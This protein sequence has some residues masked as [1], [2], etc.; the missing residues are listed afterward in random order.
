MRFAS[1]R[2]FHLAFACCTLLTLTACRAPQQRGEGL[3]L[4]R[5]AAPEHA[6]WLDSLDLQS[7][8]QDWGTPQVGRSVDGN[9]LSLRG[10]VYPR[11]VGTHAT[12]VIRVDLGGEAL[13][14]H[15]IAGVDDEVEQRGSVQFIVDIDGET[16][17][18]SAVLRGGGDT[19]RVDIDLTGARMMELL[20]EDGGDDINFDHADWAGALLVMKP[21]ARH[22]PRIIAPL[23]DVTM[24]IAKGMSD[25]PSINGPAITGATPGNPFLYR[26]P[27]TG[28]RPLTFSAS[29]LPAGLQLDSQ[30]GIIS[31]TLQAAGSTDVELTVQGPSGAATRV[32]KIVGGDDALA[33]TP[34]LGWNSW[35]AFGVA[36]DDAKIRIA[37]DWMVASGLADHGYQYVNIDDAWAGERD[38]EGRIQ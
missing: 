19:Q 4:T 5:D 11:G 12:G 32:L 3:D 1:H 8:E 25:E 13:S 35:N 31:G 29:N 30:T 22:E 34:P 10:V 37:A 36:I 18:E 7:V 24:P 28:A 23:P 21:D 2:R 17:F 20:L 38:A 33:L 14:F 6:V 15:A 9:L 16:V 27:A 26:I